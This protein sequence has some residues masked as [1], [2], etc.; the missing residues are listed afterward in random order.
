MDWLYVLCAGALEVIGV[1]YLN[2]WK[3]THRLYIILVLITVFLTS[4]L[5]LH[6]AMYTLPMSITYA[7]W[8][9]IGAVGGIMLGIF[10]YGERADWRRL[11]FLSM[12]VFSVIGLK[13][14]S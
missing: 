6:L 14:L 9:G 13:L 2:L 1:N 3:K 4:L 7:A 12:I 5:L 11:L 8:T 10:R